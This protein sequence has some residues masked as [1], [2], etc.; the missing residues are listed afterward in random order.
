MHYKASCLY[1]RYPQGAAHMDPLAATA[2]GFHSSTFLWAEL[3]FRGDAQCACPTQPAAFWN[4]QDAI[5]RLQETKNYV[6]LFVHTHKHSRVQARTQSVTKC[7]L[8]LSKQTHTHTPSHAHTLTSIWLAHP[9][10]HTAHNVSKAYC[11]RDLQ[12]RMFTFNSFE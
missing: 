12:L 11:S 5:T 7:S 9:H 4:L 3:A 6:T 8:S 2:G 10:T 1:L